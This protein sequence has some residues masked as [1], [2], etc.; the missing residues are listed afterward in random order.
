MSDYLGDGWLSSGEWVTK[1]G[2]R[3]AKCRAWIAK[4][5]DGLHSSG[6]ER[7]RSGDGWLFAG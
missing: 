7:L 1:L 2:G 6:D 4:L 5:G 3:V